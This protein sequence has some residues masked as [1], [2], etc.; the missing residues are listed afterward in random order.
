MATV[1]YS[2][3]FNSLRNAGTNV[4][5]M[6]LKSTLMDAEVAK[7]GL[8]RDQM[9]ANTAL[10]NSKTKLYDQK[11]NWIQ[12]AINDAV[13]G[14]PEGQPMTT[15]KFNRGNAAVWGKLDYPIQPIGNTGYVV[16]RA[17]GEISGGDN[18]L[19]SGNLELIRGKTRAQTALAEV[20]EA[21]ARAGGFAPR[22]GSAGSSGRARGGISAVKDLFIVP[23]T[24]KDAFGMDLTEYRVDTDAL[25]TAITQLA[26]AGY[27]PF[28]PIVMAQFRKNPDGFLRQAEAQQP[29]ASAPVQETPPADAVPQT[30]PPAAP[31]AAPKNLSQVELDTQDK[32]LE[33]VHKG[34][35]SYEDAMRIAEANGW[36]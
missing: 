31:A 8:T 25:T 20:N 9:L 33:M 19:A 13:N 3:L 2:P 32:I 29:Q 1:D 26:A 36:E 21:K 17:T 5:N 11:Y 34:K 14:V 16:N 12:T 4:A 24:V 10:A 22:S 6:A 23:V 35:M 28:D 15:D 27:N 30:T 18:P 7:A